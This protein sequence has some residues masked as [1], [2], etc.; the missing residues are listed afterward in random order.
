MARKKRKSSKRRGKRKSNKKRRSSKRG[1]CPRG[2][3]RRKGYTTKRGTRVASACIT[4][5]GAPGKG[6]KVID[7]THEGKLG[8]PGYLKK[9]EATRHKLL[10]KAVDGW[11]YRSTLGSLNALAVLGK[12]EFSKA[13][14]RKVE[15][16]REWLVKKFGGPGSFSRAGNPCMNPEVRRRKNALLR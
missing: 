10:R 6:P 2:K 4:D 11:G 12:R 8:G 16:D 7:I 13:E 15:K 14:L 9:S 3:I 1:G 5:R